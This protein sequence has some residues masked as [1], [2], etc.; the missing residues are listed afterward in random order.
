MSSR[1]NL[2]EA[3]LVA[4]LQ[5]ASNAYYNGTGDGLLADEEYDRLRDE[6]ESRFPT[7]PSLKQI[8]APV[9]KGSVKL[10]YKMAS[11]NKIKPG[12][13]A[14]QS[15]VSSSGIKAWV[16]SEKLDGISVL[17]DTGKRKLYLR[18]DGLL[19]VDVSA[20]APYLQGLTPR[21]FT[22][23]WVIRGEL[24]L[25]KETPVEGLLPRSWV[26]G[27]LHQKTPSPEELGKIRF[28]AYELLVPGSL[29][30]LQQFQQLA[31]AGF[32]VPWACVVT[33]LTD[34][35]LSQTLQARRSDSIYAIDGIVVGEN[36]V[37]KKQESGDSVEN[38]KDM[39]AFKMPL[40]DQKATTKVVDI[41]WSASYQGY[42]IPRIQIEPV[43]IGGSRIEF[44]TGHNA[45][46]I[47]ANT[48][49]KDAVI[50][51]RKSGDVIPTLERV[52]TPCPGPIGL[53]DGVWDGDA[54]TASHY[55]VKEGTLTPEMKAKKLEHFAK[56]LG[57]PF[58]G[59]G[60]I[61]KLVAEGKDTPHDL[62]TIELIDLELLVGKGMAAKVYP[63]IQKRATECS[64]LDLMLASGLMPRGVGDTK[65][66]VLF[67]QQPDPRKW[68]ALG[69]CEGWS[70][71]ALKSFHSVYPTY[72]A[73]RAQELPTIPYP[74]F[75]VSS[76]GVMDGPSLKA[77]GSFCL[78]GFRDAGFQAKLEAKGYTFASSVSKKLTALIVKDLDETSEKIQKAKALGLRILTRE[79]AEVEY[80]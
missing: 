21:C 23:K 14:V 8:G 61:T 48:I 25:Q 40:D 77:Q 18:G 6:L 10:P 19:G 32:E 71:E 34:E 17:W 60:Q 53:P 16:L 4:I 1:S 41:V 80:L 66:R 79:Q 75:N 54:Q 31:E 5:K 42:W 56:T 13:G 26:N 3:Q 50:V 44:L 2:S 58:L 57:I 65:L 64:E 29:S 52:V 15:F 67:Q 30:R 46:T 24:L 11:L 45:R 59:P 74:R 68:R 12:S 43:L 37:P 78:T 9:E 20:F 70:K 55:K 63:E 33:S 62:L 51:V 28:V 72:E 22:Q 49:G 7:N 76:P 27:Q 36:C 39:R 73:W 69:D 47:V 38:P 35:T